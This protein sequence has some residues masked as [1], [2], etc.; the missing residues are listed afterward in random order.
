MGHVM[1]A[2]A[3]IRIM[4]GE[5]M[6]NNAVLSAE[7]EALKSKISALEEQIKP[8]PKVSE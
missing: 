5:L 3:R 7:N 8:E 4:I 6:V 1:D 2:D